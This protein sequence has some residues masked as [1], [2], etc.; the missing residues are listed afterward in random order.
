MLS[1]DAA[2]RLPDQNI[3]QAVSR[4]P[5]ISVERDQGQARYISLRGAPKNWTTLSFNGIN[6]IS[7]EGRD[8]RY[9]SIP[10]AIASQVIVNKAV[11]PDMSGETIAGNVDIITRT[12][13]DQKGFR[14]SGKLGYG[15]GDLGN[16]DE[17]EAYALLA[18]NFETGIGNIGVL[19]SGSY[20]AR[21]IATDNFETDWEQVPENTRAGA[22]DL[23][24]ARE[25][26]RKYYRATRR[27]YSATGRIDW[28]PDSDNRVWVESIYTAFTDAEQRD[29]YIF[30][31]DDQQG[32]AATRAALALPCPTTAPTVPPAGTT[33]Y[34]DTCLNTPFKGTIYGIDINSNILIRRYVQ[35][36]F[37]N[38]IG[39]DHKFG[40]GWSLKWRG[41]YSRSLDDRSAPAQ[42]NFDSPGFGSAALRPTVTYDLS[43][44]N[45]NGIQLF[46]TT[47]TGS[48]ATQQL[49]RGA[50][51]GNIQNFTLP[52]TR[53]RSLTANDTTTAYT[54]RLEIGR[55]MDMFGG[56]TTFRI[57]AQYDERTKESIESS[58]DRSSAADLAA[59]AA[60]GIPNTNQGFA[61]GGTY[62]G[63]IAPGYDFRH[64]NIDTLFAAG[65]TLNGLFAKA[66]VT[67]NFYK[68][69]EKV[70]TGYAIFQSKFDWGS[71]IGGVRYENVK[72]TGNAFSSVTTVTNSTTV[73]P[74][75]VTNNIP[76]T[77]SSTTSLF[78]PSLHVNVNVDDTKK[79]RVG[80]TSGAARADY[81]QLRP[82]LTVNDSN[83]SISGGNPAAKPERAYGVDAYFEWYVRPQGFVSVGVF[84]KR[85]EDVLFNTRRTF[86]SDSLNFGGVDRSQYAFSGIT[87]GGS[88]YLYGAEGA[89]QLQLEPYTEQ[90]GLP[91]WMGGFGI[92]ANLTVNTSKVDKPAV[93]SATGTLLR[94]LRQ[95]R[96]PG[97][98]DTVYNIGGYY[99]KYGL[100]LRV[101]YQKR[102]D[103]LDAVTDTLADGG[104]VYWRADDELDVSARY[105]IRKG[106]EVYFDAS[107]LLNGPGV[108][109][110]NDRRYTIEYEQFGRRFTGGVRVT[111]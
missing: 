15:K 2:G 108:R 62:V 46:Q 67:A 90:L 39:G 20:Y 110:T 71:V 17:V 18:N 85:V 34:G 92:S 59:V 79:L 19:V 45:Y 27:N 84:Y 35:S 16:R 69:T 70:W 11:T 12:G 25:T 109:Y 24:F 80:L 26:E 76:V 68:V 54:G 50:G 3:A 5:G 102:T 37:T 44:P 78:F 91:A 101:Q 77:S 6:I 52:L 29:N 104:D 99:E 93:F 58:I 66:P 4:L 28:Q 56:D 73:P 95:T 64:F 23:F 94:P 21:G 36:I 8:S 81:D 9:D 100:S 22:S 86:N 47:V 43:N 103:W 88:G 75:T 31:F 105:E 74:T 60:A 89:V 10:T 72:N 40:D 49:G 65:N 83:L 32:S 61:T 13:L 63:K 41:N 107:N 14:F 82:N 51:V 7:P 57:G 96:L 38:T 1:S 42:F 106:I 98:S 111:F 33:G 30:D 48:G 53:V 55:T 97:T 87:N